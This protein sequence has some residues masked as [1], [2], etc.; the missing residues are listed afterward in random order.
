[1]KAI[2][3]KYLP[4]TVRKG[5]RYKA[6]AEG[7]LS[8]TLSRDYELNGEDD[9]RRAALALMAK[10]QWRSRISGAGGLANGD[11]VFTLA[12]CDAA[13][14]ASEPSNL[15]RAESVRAPLRLFMDCTGSES[16]TA[17]HDL[18]CNLAHFLKRQGLEP[19][20]AFAKALETYDEETNEES[21]NV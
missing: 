17:A 14:M 11:Y 2:Q 19:R 13:T 8:F 15:D 5:A 9:A 1:M 4:P 21:E 7:G 16:D 12:H 20:E 18:L 3:V 6:F 10:M